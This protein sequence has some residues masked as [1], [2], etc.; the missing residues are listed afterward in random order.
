MLCKES[1]YSHKGVVHL[2]TEGAKTNPSLVP[3][4]RPPEPLIVV[5]SFTYLIFRIPYNKSIT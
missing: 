4:E 2:L 1:K 3:R 5:Y